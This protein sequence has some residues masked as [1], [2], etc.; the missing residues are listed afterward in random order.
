MPSKIILFFL[1][2]FPALAE[3]QILFEKSI[4][5]GSSP[6]GNSIAETPDHGFYIGGSFN[7][8]NSFGGSSEF[9]FIGRADSNGKV[10]WVRTISGFFNGR[11][12]SVIS[13]PDGGA[14]AAGFGSSGS[15]NL[16]TVT[17]DGSGNER[18]SYLSTFGLNQSSSVSMIPTLDAGYICAI[19]S[20]GEIPIFKFNGSG[21]LQWSVSVIQQTFNLS[22]AAEIIQLADGSFIL[23]SG[24]STNFNSEVGIL[25]KLSSS[26]SLLWEHTL[27][28]AG[29][30]TDIT[31]TQDNGFAITGMVSDSLGS[32]QKEYVLKFDS[33]GS[34]LWQTKIDALANEEVNTIT[35]LSNGDLIVAGHTFSDNFFEEFFPP[36]DNAL[37]ERFQSDGTPVSVQ[38]LN[39]PHFNSQVIKIIRTHDDGIAMTGTLSNFTSSFS[40]SQSV[41]LGKTDSYLGGCHMSEGLF[42]SLPINILMDTVAGFVSQLNDGHTTLPITSTI[43][44]QE[45]DMCDPNP[46]SDPLDANISV[47]PNPL[48]V[49]EQLT[50]SF[51]DNIIPAGFY[52]LSVRDILRRVKRQ[53]DIYLTGGSKEFILDVQGLTT[54]LYFVEL[55]G[56]ENNTLFRELK[57]IKE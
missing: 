1:L 47:Y 33:D 45:T 5:I 37:I 3:G 32:P 39:F 9:P 24:P 21:L 40:I 19:L 53:V 22:G 11:I 7:T 14:V 29:I 49:G 12:F 44:Y 57:F 27:L 25:I 10:L 38:T 48:P 34:L 35:E 55:H 17:F 50:V 26:G 2:L 52:Q 56:G 6:Q 15:D 43:E 4:A 41:L 23:C 46:A 28:N 51:H 36:T 31:K 54:G 8:N 18:G 42:S 16:F 13:T 30:M 20:S